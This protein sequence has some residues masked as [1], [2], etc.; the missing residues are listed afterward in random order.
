[1]NAVLPRAVAEKA[2]TVS[3]PSRRHN[4]ADDLRRQIATGRIN[5]GERLRSEADLADRYKVST[6]TL[7]RALSVLQVEGL[8]EKV[9]GKSNF[10]RLPLRKIMYVGGWGTR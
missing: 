5:P 3:V 4:I 1:V 6:V 8:V 7:R 9:H 2:V 10:V